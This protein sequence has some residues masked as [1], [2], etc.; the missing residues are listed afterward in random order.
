MKLTYTKAYTELE[1]LV[2]AIE[3]DKIKVDELAE[4]I[5]EANVMIK[6]CEEKLRGITEEIKKSSES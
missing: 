5:K 4:K 3:D 6:Y 2:E 1:K